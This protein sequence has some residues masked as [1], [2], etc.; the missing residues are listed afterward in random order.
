LADKI[1]WL[2]AKKECS[3]RIYSVVVL[4]ILICCLLGGCGYRP[5]Y[6]DSAARFG[7]GATVSIPIFVNKT[8]KPNL[9]N[10]LL[11][12]LIDEFAKRKGLKVASGDVSDYTL[13]GELQ[14]Y[15]K[16]AVSYSGSDIIKEYKAIL[17]MLA[18]FRNNK[19]QQVL[20]R[21]ELSWSQDYPANDDIAIQQNS[22]DAAIMEISRRLAQR[23]YLKINEDF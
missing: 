9:E 13:S 12:Q 11:N 22:E 14:S 20:W 16:S 3:V 18:T 15:D 17:T 4:S 21:G 5:L 7:E 23:L 10:I 19:T 1:P 8:F 6:Q 2:L